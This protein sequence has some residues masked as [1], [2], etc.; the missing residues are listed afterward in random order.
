[1]QFSL[2]TD[3]IFFWTK[4]ISASCLPV[5]AD[6]SFLKSVLYPL[7]DITFIQQMSKSSICLE[8][9]C[10]PAILSG[11]KN[12]LFPWSERR[13][14]FYGNW[15]EQNKEA[16][17]TLFQKTSSWIYS[18]GNP[19]PLPLFPSSHC[20][21]IPSSSGQRESPQAVCLFLRMKTCFHE[22]YQGKIWLCGSQV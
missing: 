16:C 11:L 18:A 9:L 22:L 21:Q 7:S 12:M 15:F 13:I 2:L 19:S 4:G 5:F 6:A 3:S 20:W 17:G 8:S 10:S 14:I 1:M